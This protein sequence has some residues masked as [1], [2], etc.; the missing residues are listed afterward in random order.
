MGLAGL[1]IRMVRNRAMC[2]LRSCP[3]CAGFGCVRVE[4]FAIATASYPARAVYL[5]DPGDAWEGDR[6]PAG[7]MLMASMS[8]LIKN[9][10]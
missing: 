2:W 6:R 3:S 4:C 1:P 8:E 7:A 10:N 9:H 5:Y